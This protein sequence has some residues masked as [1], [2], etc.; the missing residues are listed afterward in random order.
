MAV[1][2]NLFNKG[3]HFDPATLVGFMIPIAFATLVGALIY[4]HANPIKAPV[5]QQTNASGSVTATTPVDPPTATEIATANQII[6][7][8]CSSDLRAD[9][10]CALVGNS[11]TTAPG[12]VET[13]LKMNG[14]FAT[15]GA[16]TNGL[17]LAKGSGS[18]WAVVWVG[19]GCIPQDIATEYAVPS[20]LNICAS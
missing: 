15:D 2:G 5:A 16:S 7:S 10:S 13:G 4:A 3:K 11:T 18:S 17:A 6:L 8:Y 1:L 20:S 14:T 19:Q 9:T 12:F